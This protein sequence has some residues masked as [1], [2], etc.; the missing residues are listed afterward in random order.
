MP[1]SVY[2]MTN[3]PQ[4]TLYVGVTKDLE[5]R[6]NQHK[7]DRSN[8]FVARYKLHTMVWAQ[9][10]IDVEEAIAFEKRLKRWR[11][12][13]KIRLIEEANPSWEAIV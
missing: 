3:R 5:K 7:Q 1:F 8:S 11:R 10:F 4:G 9:E 6:A 13:W 2:I 12:N